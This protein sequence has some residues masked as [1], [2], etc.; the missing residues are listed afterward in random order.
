MY[1][2]VTNVIPTQKIVKTIT[3]PIFHEQSW[4]DWDSELMEVVRAISDKIDYT[5]IMRSREKGHTPHINLYIKSIEATP[6]D[7][8]I[9]NETGFRLVIQYQ[10][11][12]VYQLNSEGHHKHPVDQIDMI[13]LPQ[14]VSMADLPVLRL[15]TIMV[16]SLK[17]T[18][19]KAKVL[20]TT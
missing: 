13:A 12:E 6:I 17:N 16:D 1:E 8:E 18:F 11:E 5:K 14:G 15:G 2:S 9:F 10:L 4:L 20:S 3:R 7:I 19:N